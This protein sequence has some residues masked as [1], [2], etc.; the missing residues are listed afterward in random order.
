MGQRF[1]CPAALTSNSAAPMA[2]PSLKTVLPKA[3]KKNQQPS[4]LGRLLTW[5]I[6]VPVVL[7]LMLSR[8]EA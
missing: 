3:S 1:G 7:V 6:S 5:T 2:S 8:F 4:L